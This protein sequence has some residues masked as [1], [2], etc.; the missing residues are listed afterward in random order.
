MP[1]STK[2][3]SIKSGMSPGSLVHIGEAKTEKITVHLFDYDKSQFQERELQRV[4]DVLPLLDKTGVSWI[5]IA[6]L[7]DIGVIEKVGDLFN[8]HPLILEDILNTGQRPKMTEFDTYIYVVFKMLQF[9]TEEG[10]I[11]SEQI[12]LVVGDHFLLSFQEIQGDVFDSVRERIRKGKGRIRSAGCSYLAYT[13][14]DAVVDQYYSVIE[15][16]GEKIE[17]MEE[18]LLEDSPPM[19]SGEIHQLKREMIHFRKQVLP[20]RQLLNNLLKSDSPLIHRSTDVFISDIYDHTI[21]VI[22]TLE[23]YRDILSGLLEVYLSTLSNK[24]NQVM[25]V[26]TVIAT[27]FIPLTFIVGI[28][29]M[30]FKYMPELEWKWGYFI[31][32]GFMILVGLVMLAVFKK[33]KWL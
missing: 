16:I 13:L 14:I 19:L 31:T 5:D 3:R 29:G 28:Y 1:R 6:G 8:I 12:S 20:M 2:R 22:D 30:N 27:I 4:E 26:L 10:R 32:W 33:R 11:D 23:S 15:L 25:K 24:M 9:N 7:H 18:T 21:Q 17:K